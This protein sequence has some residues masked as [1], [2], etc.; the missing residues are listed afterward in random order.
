VT[1]ITYF[2]THGGLGYLAVVLDLI[3]RWIVGWAMQGRPTANLAPQ[4]LLAAV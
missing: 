1:D 4:A 2:R 3:S